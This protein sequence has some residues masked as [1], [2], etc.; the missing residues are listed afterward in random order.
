MWFKSSNNTLITPHDRGVK[1]VFYLSLVVSA[2]SSPGSTSS[3]QIWEGCTSGKSHGEIGDTE[4]K[5][6]IPY[7]SY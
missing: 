4:T 2:H 3:P 7:N 1:H 6:N 5:R